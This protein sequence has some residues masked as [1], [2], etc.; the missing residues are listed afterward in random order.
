MTSAKCVASEPYAQTYQADWYSLSPEHNTLSVVPLRDEAGW[1]YSVTNLDLLHLGKQPVP[2]CI[3]RRHPRLLVSRAIQAAQ[4]AH[5][6][7]PNVEP[8]HG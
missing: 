3:P 5:L 8:E 1:Q 7:L 6:V 2:R 4:L